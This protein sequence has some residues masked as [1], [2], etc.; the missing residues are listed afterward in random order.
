MR[1][2]WLP[3]V[4]LAFAFPVAADAYRF[5]SP[6]PETLGWIVTA[7]QARNLWREWGAGETLAF[8]LDAS[9]D[10]STHYG[11]LAGIRRVVEKGL[12]AWSDLPTADI[13]WALAGVRA[14]DYGESG[15][16]SRDVNWVSI[17]PSLEDVRGR[18]STWWRRGEDG[19]QIT[20]CA[21][22]LGSWATEPLSDRLRDLPADDPRRTHVALDTIIHEF[23]HCLGLAHAQR[24][25]TRSLLVPEGENLWRVNTSENWL[26][27]P[28][29][30]Y[31]WSDLGIDHPVT[32]DDAAGAALLRPAPG[33]LETTGTISGSLLFKG[34][35]VPHA[36]VWA[37][38]EAAM[39]KGRRPQPVGAFS[40]SE[41]R[42][43]IE[44]LKPG[45]YAL[46]VSPLT[47]RR[48]HTPLLEA[49]GPSRLGEVTLPWP[50]RVE[51]GSVTEMKPIRLRHQRK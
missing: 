4:A 1:R 12:A 22:T 48:A 32:A 38:P 30:S 16:K 27:D 41:G 8:T 19:W 42:F 34:D 20:Q 23:G 29:M 31:G 51:A 45:R 35:P 50:V 24:L 14:S 33:W 39:P 13:S 37:F 17:D 43:R 25:P 10:W 3:T 11:D 47:E 26:A 6:D 28:Q 7:E 9:A 15:P 36:H 5:Y 49:A 21:V 40:D 2:R 44:G 46:Q 18:A